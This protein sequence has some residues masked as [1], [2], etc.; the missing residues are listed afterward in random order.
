MKNKYEIENEMTINKIIVPKTKKHLP[1][2]ELPYSLCGPTTLKQPPCG[3]PYMHNVRG[4]I[5]PVK[6]KY[7]IPNEMTIN[8]IIALKNHLPQSELPHSLCGP[9]TLKQSLCGHPHRHDVRGS[10]ATVKNKY[11]IQNEMTINKIIVQNQ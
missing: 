2:P 4:S 5:D 10:I 11:K 8:K 1:S 3:H 9:T 6:N 7:K